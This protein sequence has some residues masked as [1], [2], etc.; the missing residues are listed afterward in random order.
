MLRIREGENII[1]IYRRH[2]F[3]LF[4][5]LL[6]VALGS[7]IV[8]AIS[9]FILFFLVNGVAVLTPFILL[10]AFLVLHISWVAAFAILT[11]FYLDVWVLTNK[12]TLF[13]EQ[14]GLFSRRIVDFELHKIEDITVDIRG[15][16]ETFLDFGNIT[17]HTASDNPNFVFKHIKNPD[18]V[19]DTVVSEIRRLKD[20][21][22]HMPDKKQSQLTGFS[23]YDI[24]KATIKATPTHSGKEGE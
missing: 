5:E 22:E 18:T 14:I 15:V 3:I 19:K 6:P 1:S 21:E 4:L 7:F 23:F 13:I 16:V 9:F 20:R 17:L 10:V 2:R 24:I 11:D 12:R 8:I